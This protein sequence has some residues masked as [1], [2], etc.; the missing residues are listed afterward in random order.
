MWSRPATRP[1]S[2]MCLSLGWTSRT[3]CLSSWTHSQQQDRLRDCWAVSWNRR[4]W[5]AGH[6]GRRGLLPPGEDTGSKSAPSWGSE[7]DMARGADA[8]RRVVEAR[9]RMPHSSGQAWVSS[10][11]EPHCVSLS[12]DQ[13]YFC[14]RTSP[15]ARVAFS[16][17]GGDSRDTE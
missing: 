3:P 17:K 13:C 5:G 7:A 14:P 1:W 9:A 12:Q 2:A 4:G 16:N 8:G 6:A 10:P 15:A 11:W